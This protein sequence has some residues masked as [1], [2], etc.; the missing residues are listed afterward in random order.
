MGSIIDITSDYTASPADPLMLE[1]PDTFL[2]DILVPGAVV[3]VDPEDA[4]RA[5]AF[6]EDALSPEDAEDAQFDARMGE[7][8][9]VR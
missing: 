1:A 7:G 3:E 4:E 8:A 5:G 9:H 2:A 6:V